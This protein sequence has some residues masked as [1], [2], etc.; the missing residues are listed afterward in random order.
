MHSIFRTIDLIIF[1]ANETPQIEKIDILGI[2][3][4]CFNIN[5]FSYIASTVQ[6]RPYIPAR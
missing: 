3:G 1:L 6:G 2:F 5:S 4:C